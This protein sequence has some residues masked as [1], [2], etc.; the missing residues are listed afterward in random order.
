[1][2]RLLLERIRTVISWMVVNVTAPD[3]VFM[4]TNSGCAVTTPPADVP[5]GRWLGIIGLKLPTERTLLE[6]NV[7]CPNT[8]PAEF[9][10]TGRRK[11]SAKMGSSA[12]RLNYKFELPPNW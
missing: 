2:P 1:M 10:R 6:T 3:H 8:D 11:L 12:L 4:E 5:V 9:L 7:S